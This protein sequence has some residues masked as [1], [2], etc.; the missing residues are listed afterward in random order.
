MRVAVHLVY[1]QR[2]S[3]GLETK[4]M[5][6]TDLSTTVEGMPTFLSCGHGSLLN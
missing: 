3:L 6:S 5:R 2:Q 1:P 4:S